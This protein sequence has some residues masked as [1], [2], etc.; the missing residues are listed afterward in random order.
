MKNGDYVVKDQIITEAN[1]VTNG[2]E[3]NANE[4]TYTFTELPKYDENG[5]EIQYTVDETEVLTNDLYHYEKTIGE[6]TNKV[7]ETNVKQA[8]ITN[9][10]TKIPSTVVVKYVDKYTGDEIADE[11]TKEGIIG[12]PF[13]VTEDVKDIEGYTLV[14]E[15][16]EK[17]GTYTAEPQEKIYYYAKNTSVIVKYL[18][19]DDTPE[20]TADNKVLAKEKTMLGHEGERYV[21]S[22][23]DID[24]YTLVAT[25]DNTTGT[26]QREE[27]VVIY[28]YAQNTK[29]TV[30]YLEK[31]DTPNDNSD[32]KVLAPEKTIN[33]HVGETYTTEEQSIPNYTCIEKT[34]NYEGTMTKEPIEVIYYYAQ[35]T[36]V[37][38]KYLEKDDTPEDNTDNVVLAQEEILEGYAGQEYKTEEKTVTNYTLVETTENTEGTMT[39]EII[40]VIYYYA[41]NTKATVQHIDRE[42]G[43][44]LKQETQNGKVGDLF[45]THAE[46]FE[47]YVLVESPEEPNI[48]MDKTGEQIV[49]YYY[50]HM[51]AGVIEKHIDEITGELLYSEEHEGNEGDHY[52]IPSREFEGYDLVTEDKDGNSRLP[53]NAEGEMTEDLIEVK[54][55][56]IKKAS[57]IVKYLEE[58]DTPD[59]DTDNKVLAKEEIIEGHENDSYETEA[60]DIKDYNLVGTPEN[61][62]GIMTITQNSD[63]TYNTQITVIYYYKEKAGGVIENHI[64]IT[65]GNILAIEKH[66]GNVG[67]P[68]DIPSRNF[69][70]YDLVEVDSEGNNRLP[71]NAQ[72]NM[73]EEE[74]VVNYYYIKRAKVKVEYIDKITGEK[75]DE[76]ELP[77][78]VGDSYTTEEKK[79]DGYELI[80]KPS[81]STGE[82]TEGEIVV[83]YYYA[84]KA[85]VEVKYL[86]K[87]TD[88]EVASSETIDGYVGDK[89]ETSAKDIPYYKFVESTDNTN[90]TMEKDKI[91]VIYYYEKQVFNIG[92]DKWVASVNVNGISEGAKTINNKDEMYVVD[93]HR[94]KTDTADVRVTYKIRVTNKGEI[95]GS[96][97]EIIEYIPEGYSYYPEDN[98][99]Q[100]EE[101]NGTFVTNALANEV[102]QPG[103]YKEIEIVLRWNRGENNFGEKKNVV[104]ISGEENPA[105]FAD[106]NKEDN[107]STADM[108]ITV[109][110]G[111]DRN[112]R[113]ILNVVLQVLIFVAVVL[114]IIRRKR[115]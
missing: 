75:L 111:L 85:E 8:T 11:K 43:E 59:D 37:V 9:T 62:K 91:T 16:E 77:G 1:A 56:Y 114:L 90:G 58:D 83:K 86:E 3:T 72:G 46:D 50:A 92:I 60:K 12:D 10:M 103:Q 36:K 107:Q 28:Y 4:W 102:I 69:D 74:I 108:M 81:N 55:Y 38:V 68:Y 64:D 54:Y 70:G 40:E 24:G 79:F 27:I 105:G 76:E 82:M 67:D 53:E 65:T 35:N 19:Q 87:G 84:R 44:I 52:N 2:D 47:G 96:V 110:T 100:W 25:T 51:S 48:I 49:K 20:N 95:E 71:D 88:Y 15:P 26:M 112:G 6:V 57:V 109:A 14:E 66:E 97:G 41:Q 13:D 104:A 98:S 99:I 32:N 17:T 22:K 73:T 34:T 5:Q 18:E 45:E 23:E 78:H 93:I 7:G 89:Y 21:T 113:F 94:S 101:R 80:E 31:D 33:G 29:V 63:G 39:K 106:S 30:K 42:T 61:A 115:K